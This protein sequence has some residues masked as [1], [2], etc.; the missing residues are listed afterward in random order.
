[1]KRIILVML[2]IC[3][4][5]FAG[6][7]ELTREKERTKDLNLIEE[8]QLLLR[9]WRSRRIG[10]LKPIV[11][12]TMRPSDYQNN[13]H[14]GTVEHMA[15]WKNYSFHEVEIPDGSE[16]IGRNFSQIATNTDAI[17]RK[18]GL[19][20]NLTFRDCNLT[21]VKTYPDW[22]LIGSNNAQVDRVRDSDEPIFVAPKSGDVP[23]DRVKPEGVLE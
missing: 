4:Q 1:M 19:G 9:G 22:T 16:V 15:N 21:N 11:S 23:A 7:D 8:A 2:L 13:F 14:R 18:P 20:H 5:A 12:S 6:M 3:S 17:I 10:E